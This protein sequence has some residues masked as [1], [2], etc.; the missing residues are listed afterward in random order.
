MITGSVSS[1]PGLPIADIHTRQ[2]RESC[3]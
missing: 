3:W 1:T 2:E